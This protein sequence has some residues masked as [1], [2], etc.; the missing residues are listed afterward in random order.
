MKTDFPIIIAG[1]GPTGLLLGCL[2][3]NKNIPFLILEPRSATSTHSR[4]IGI[5]PPSLKIFKEMGLL[6]KFLRE[7]NRVETGIAC[8]G[9]RKIGN[10]HFNELKHPHPFILTL[11]Q[12]VTERI[13]EE[14]LLELAPKS[15]RRECG[16]TGF[17]SY[18][19]YVEVETS[20]GDR[21]SAG[22]L[23]GCDGKESLVRKL[24]GI[25]YNVE[26]YP[27]TY[28][29]GDFEDTF[30]N[31]NEAVVHLCK[32]GLIE[33]FPHGKNLRRW[34]V[35]T[36]AFIENPTVDLLIQDIQQRLGLSP[37]ASTN[38]MISSF[39]VQRMMAEQF[40]KGRIILAGDA[41]HVVSPIGGQGM[42][43]GWLDV[44]ALVEIMPQLT[45]SKLQNWESKRKKSAGIA[46]QRAAFNMRMGRKYR[47]EFL[48]RIMVK[49]LLT[50]PIRAVLM[51]QFTMDGL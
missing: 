49:T 2:L 32:E 18:N 3:A 34:V 13:L 36:D 33:S 6:D 11:S 27:D 5:H 4:S 45:T 15:L 22:H 20:D 40:L 8:I 38:R 42:N 48:R 19:D 7:G 17:T 46:A 26:F 1:A 29:M 9:N 37:D 25:E 30:A 21:I 10:I 41:A 39:R 16:L 47:S 23:V 31:R 14:K 12:A 28:I 35:K 43:L 50:R 44:T 51:K 24:A